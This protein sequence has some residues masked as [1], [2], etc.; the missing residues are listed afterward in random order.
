MASALGRYLFG[1]GIVLWIVHFKE[2]PGL[3][4]MLMVGYG[5]VK[6]WDNKVKP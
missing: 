2:L 6:G 3:V 1:W 5:A 4:G